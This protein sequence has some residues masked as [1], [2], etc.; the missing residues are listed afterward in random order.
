MKC[1]LVGRAWAFSIS[2]SLLVGCSRAL[3]GG[4][5]LLDGVEDPICEMGEQWLSQG[6]CAVNELLGG[7]ALQKC[8]SSSYLLL[9]IDIF[10]HCNK[11]DRNSAVMVGSAD[12]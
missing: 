8:K 4:S 11:Q 1:S 3:G 5:P 10:I 7:R 12:V 6:C 9:I 2:L